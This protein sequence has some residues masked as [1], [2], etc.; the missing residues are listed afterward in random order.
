M[1]RLAEIE[2]RKAEIRSLL[3]SEEMVD[4]EALKSELESLSAEKRSIEERKEIAK[5]IQVGSFQARTIVT[6]EERS[7]P[8]AGLVVSVI[9]IPATSEAV[10]PVM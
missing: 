9:E 10:L 8:S 2:A 7:V 4:L 1:K 3:Q 6:E 5:S